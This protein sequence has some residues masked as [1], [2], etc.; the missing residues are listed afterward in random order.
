MA[1]SHADCSS[2]NMP[3]AAH[4]S[5]QDDRVSPTQPEPCRSFAQQWRPQLYP[6]GPLQAKHA[7]LN[8][9]RLPALLAFQTLILPDNHQI[10]FPSVAVDTGLSQGGSDRARLDQP[11][12]VQ[13][14]VPN[15][16]AP[17]VSGRCSGL[18]VHATCWEDAKL[19]RLP[20]WCSPGS[21]ISPGGIVSTARPACGLLS[22]CCLA[23]RAARPGQFGVV[24]PGP[25]RA[26]RRLVG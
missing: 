25:A 1:V 11:R 8:C 17:V 26:K 20:P 4:S 5:V 18:H 22:L 12:F 19:P 13:T 23:S 14:P 9:S 2:R 21:L 16:I 24:L 3:A 6:P 10:G 15:P 7:L